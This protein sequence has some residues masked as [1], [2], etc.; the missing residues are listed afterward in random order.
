MMVWLLAY[1]IKS[2]CFVILSD[3]GVIKELNVFCIFPSL[4]IKILWKFHFGIVE[5]PKFFFAHLYRSWASL[6][7]T[8]VLSVIG[9]V[10]LKLVSQKSLISKLVPGSS[11]PN[12]F[13]GTPIT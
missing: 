2:N 12:W 8:S 5:L 6:P 7:L 3:I 1:R 4:L 11:P 13:D 10:I 9:K